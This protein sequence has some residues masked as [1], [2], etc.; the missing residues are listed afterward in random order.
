MHGH[1]LAVLTKASVTLQQVLLQRR[2]Q[3]MSESALISPRGCEYRRRR[4]AEYA[5]GVSGLI[6]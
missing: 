1:T 3:H 5:A 6:H 2:L 4:N